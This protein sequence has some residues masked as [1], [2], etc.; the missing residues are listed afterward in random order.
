[1]RFRD[2]LD[3]P[4]DLAELIQRLRWEPWSRYRAN[5]LGDDAWFGWTPEVALLAEVVDMTAFVA[6]AAGQNPKAKYKQVIKRPQQKGRAV[7]APKS[8][9]DMD[10]AAFFGGLMG[11]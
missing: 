6:R 9:K 11:Q 2:E 5:L 7:Y 10:L 8:I 1:M 4:D 3:H